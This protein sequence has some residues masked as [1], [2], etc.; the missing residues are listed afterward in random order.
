MQTSDSGK[1]SVLLLGLIE[2]EGQFRPALA[3]G[4]SRFA[5]SAFG[6]ALGLID[7]SPVLGST[8]VTIF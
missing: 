8:A 4:Q 2:A 6:I 7:L 1:Y 5:S 3:I